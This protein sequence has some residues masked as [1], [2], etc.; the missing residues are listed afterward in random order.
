METVVF[1]MMVIVCF[2]YVLKQTSRKPYHVVLSATVCGLCVGLTWPYAIEQSKFPGLL[3]YPVLFS[4]LVATIFALPGKS[5]PLIAWSLAA[6][7]AVVVIAG[8][9]ALKWLVPVRDVRL[10]LLF[11][12]NALIGV[13]GIVATV[14]GTTSVETV[15]HVDWMAMASVAVMILLGLVV[16]LVYYKVKLI[17]KSK[18]ITR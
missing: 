7:V 14:N 6:V 11:L 15:S 8:C 1:V 17:R 5:Y 18:S 9:R 2:N 3:I 13:L 16:G 4:I 12:S 10:E